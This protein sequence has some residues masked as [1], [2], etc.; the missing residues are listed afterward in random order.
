MKAIKKPIVLKFE[1]AT[2]EHDIQTK[3]GPASC[4][5]GSAILT[6]TQG[7]RWPILRNTFDRDYIAD[8][9]S[10]TC[11]KKPI[12]VEVEQR[13]EPFSVVVSWRKGELTGKAGDWHVTYGPND[14][15]IVDKDIFAE[16]Y[17]LVGVEP[18]KVEEPKIQQK[19]VK[20]VKTEAV[21][22]IT[23]VIVEETV[24]TEPVKA[25]EVTVSEPE[26][27]EDRQE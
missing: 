3:E 22:V 7:E 8:I 18:V 25:E 24:V 5:I 16:T 9:A 20:A 19:K 26:P 27:V 12:E 23:P 15:G 1:F 4:E 10:G 21:E 6:G 17:D 11:Y 13:N 2:R 14:F